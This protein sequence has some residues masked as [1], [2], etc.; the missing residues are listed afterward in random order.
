MIKK[1]L[2]EILPAVKAH[3]VEGLKYIKDH[4]E[5]DNH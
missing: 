5:K 4:L 1:Y 2:A 3:E